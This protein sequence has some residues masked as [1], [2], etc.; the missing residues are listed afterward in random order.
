M[1]LVQGVIG[2][3]QIVYLEEQ[4]RKEL[5][6][7]LMTQPQRKQEEQSFKSFPLPASSQKLTLG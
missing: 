4:D 3:A 5:A 2:K 7:P 1:S 6:R